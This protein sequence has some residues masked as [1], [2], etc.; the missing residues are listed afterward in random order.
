MF[1]WSHHQYAPSPAS[2]PARAIIAVISASV[3][4]PPSLGTSSTVAPNACIVRRFSLL[5]A[6]EKTMWQP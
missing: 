2:S 4:R 1:S 5:N 3:M 6:S